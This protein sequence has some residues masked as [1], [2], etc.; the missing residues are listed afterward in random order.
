M[1]KTLCIGEILWDIFPDRKV[2]GGAPANFIYHTAQ[3]GADG[4]AFTAVGKDEL[5]KE[6]VDIAL[7]SGVKIIAEEVDF[8]TGVVNISVDDQGVP[9][10]TFNENCSWDHIPFNEKL[11]VL[12]EQADLISFGTLAQRN[13]VSRQTILSGLKSRKA[14]AK[15][16]FDINLRQNFYTREIIEN[17]LKYADFLKLNEDEVVVIQEITGKSINE[18]ISLHNLELVILTLGANGSRIIT[19]KQDYFH[20][21]EK[22]RV[23]DTVG[24]GDAFTACFIMNYLKGIEITEAQANAAAAAAYVC[25][26]KGA[27]IPIPEKFKLNL[28][29]I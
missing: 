6:L 9:D 24:A 10:Y 18:L 27:T 8:P 25:E 2:W 22:C 11:K 13:D 28:K 26:H 12:S 21:A 7:K 15:V 1:I 3:F 23:I 4:T 20:P 16:L 5:G 14:S 17:S 19:P 29:G